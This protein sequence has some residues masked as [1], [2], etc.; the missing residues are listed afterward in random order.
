[1]RFVF[2][3]AHP[4]HVHLFRYAIVELQQHGHEVMVVSR[5]KDVTVELLDH[6][7]IPHDCLSRQGRGLVGLAGEML[8]RDWRLWRLARRFRPDVFVALSMCSAHVAALLRKPCVI[9]DD[10]EHATLERMAW[11]PFA[12]L[13]CTPE[14]YR[15]HLGP[16]QRRYPGYHEL[17]YLHP[18]RFQPDP[19]AL[20]DAGIAK[21]ERFFIVR[22]V[23]WAAAHDVGHRGFTEAGRVRLVHELEKLGRVILTSEG[24]VP[25]DL[26][27]YR[28]RASPT[29]IHD[30]IAYSSLFIG[31]SSTMAAEAAL[32]GVPN[33][34]VSTIRPGT[35]TEREASGVSH[36]IDDEEEA[37]MK[38]I[39]LASDSSAGE[40]YGRLRDK[41][42]ADK[43]DVTDYLVSLLEDLGAGSDQ[44][45]R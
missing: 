41:L 36:R 22:F 24:K 37:I 28:M 34:R 14:A 7:G 20:T 30:L 18:S 19:E 2:E 11:R 39:E 35:D 40:R 12:T 32:L 25:P 23:S 38:A 17:A 13:I 16:R 44:G 29:R 27:K 33:I 15:L 4:A 45:R 42:L 3:I 21:G 1:M 26:E 8:L 6:Y 43:V 10:S 5:D 31:D 9:F